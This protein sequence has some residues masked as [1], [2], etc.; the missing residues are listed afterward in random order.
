MWR[1][2]KALPAT[3]T[4]KNTATTTLIQSFMLLI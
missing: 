3:A 2:T 4:T 1:E